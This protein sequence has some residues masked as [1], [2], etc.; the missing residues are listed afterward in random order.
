MTKCSPMR[1]SRPKLPSTR[2]TLIRQSEFFNRTLGAFGRGLWPKNVLAQLRGHYI[3][4]PQFE[5]KTEIVGYY[6]DVEDVTG[7]HLEPRELIIGDQT[8]ATLSR[9]A[10]SY[11][12]F[13]SCVRRASSCA[14]RVSPRFLA[15]CVR[16]R[17][18]CIVFVC[19]ADPEHHP[20]A[21]TM[22]LFRWF[23]LTHAEPNVLPEPVNVELSMAAAEERHASS[24]CSMHS[25]WTQSW[26]IPAVPSTQSLPPLKPWSWRC[27]CCSN[28]SAS[29]FRCCSNFSASIFRR[30][31]TF[32]LRYGLVP[33]LDIQR[34]C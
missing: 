23:K 20:A 5:A 17:R 33:P 12:S 29:I 2:K 24:V 11:L 34:T 30:C 8:L 19:F 21:L 4:L 6:V 3:C 27:C 10:Q 15:C 28:C 32:R 18:R 25:F 26:D 13:C 1:H 16:R 14:R 31:S 7:I 22:Q 9:R